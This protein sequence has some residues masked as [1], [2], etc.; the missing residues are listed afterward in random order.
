M[1]RFF[2]LLLGVYV[3]AAAY[4]GRAM[5]VQVIKQGHLEALLSEDKTIPVAAMRLVFDGG[6]RLVPEGREGVGELASY[7]IQEGAAG[8]DAEGL[9]ERQIDLAAS[10]SMS[11][12]RDG[13][14]ISI[15]S[16][17]DALPDALG[18]VM[19]MLTQPALGADDFARLKDQMKASVRR[20]MNDP[21]S[22]A[23]TAV[24]AQS[25]PGVAQGRSQTIASLNQVTLDD[26]RGFLNRQ[27]QT[28]RLLVA[29]AGDVSP[30]TTR[31]LLDV[32]QERLPRG[33]VAADEP[34]LNIQNQGRTVSSPTLPGG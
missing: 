16:V 11:N 19:D 10:I 23:F 7:L 5:S 26:V 6:K 28:E 3:A 24:A 25:Y 14:S 15:T 27:I 18:L 21:Q 1:S 30:Q 33:E 12:E 2:A 34:F 13:F 29:L 31:A 20:R 22:L 32:L 17:A 8:M 4:E 9:A